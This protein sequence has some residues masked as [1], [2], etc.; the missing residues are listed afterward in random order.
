MNG[1]LVIV[2]VIEQK[3]ELKPY[4]KNTNIWTNLEINNFQEKRKLAK[5][6]K[7]DFW[8]NYL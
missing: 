3:N 4:F 6:R 2:V 8:A 7:N 5:R 1:K